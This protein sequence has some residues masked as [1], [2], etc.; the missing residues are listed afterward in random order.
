MYREL[1]KVFRLNRTNH[2]IPTE[3]LK[4]LMHYLCS[5]AVRKEPNNLFIELIFL[6]Y[7][8]IVFDVIRNK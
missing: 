4:S 2:W 7:L 3:C 6:T 1:V 8:N 5:V